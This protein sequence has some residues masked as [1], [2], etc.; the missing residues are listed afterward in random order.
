MDVFLRSAIGLFLVFALRYLQRDFVYCFCGVDAS[1]KYTIRSCFFITSIW[2]RIYRYIKSLQ[3]LINTKTIQIAA[4]VWKARLHTQ[5]RILRNATPA[6]NPDPTRHTHTH[7]RRTR[8]TRKRRHRMHRASTCASLWGTRLPS[9]PP[10]PP[11]LSPFLRLAVPSAAVHLSLSDGWVPAR[12]DLRFHYSQLHRARC[13]RCARATL[14]SFRLSLPLR[15]SRSLFN[16]FRCR[17]RDP[18]FTPVLS[19]CVCLCTCF[20]CELNGRFRFT[21]G[22]VGAVSGEY[23]M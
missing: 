6:H 21:V 17:S 18:S 9:A 19:V 11:P 16:V 1:S 14:L 20:L 2:I 22:A 3:F 15:P 8:C 12:A 13:T 7:I 5:I 10:L 23:R 4:T